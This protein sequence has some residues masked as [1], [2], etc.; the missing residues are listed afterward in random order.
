M[1]H[2][3]ATAELVGDLDV[4]RRQRFEA[5][6]RDAVAHEIEVLHIAR[7]IICYGG[8]TGERETRFEV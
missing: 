7:G 3:S 2:D 4:V 6:D 1:G 5:E 8:E